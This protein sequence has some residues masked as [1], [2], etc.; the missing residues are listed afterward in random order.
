MK[1]ATSGGLVGLFICLLFK[2]N[3]LHHNVLWKAADLSVH[4][5]EAPPRTGGKGIVSALVVLTRPTAP[6]LGTGNRSQGEKVHRRVRGERRDE[7]RLAYH[8]IS[9]RS[10]Q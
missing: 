2:A 3:F 5:P 1:R 8:D 6:G 9:Q 4:A 7:K 10:A